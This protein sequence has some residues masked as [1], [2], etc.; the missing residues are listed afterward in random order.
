M[1]MK[2]IVN[3]RD[4][5]FWDAVLLICLLLTPL[6]VLSVSSD[7]SL[8]TGCGPQGYTGTTGGCGS[9]IQRSFFLFF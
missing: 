9:T 1:A 6:P 3:W 5:R 8:T 7:T 4:G 2:M